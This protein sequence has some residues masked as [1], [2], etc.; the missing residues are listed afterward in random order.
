M[1]LLLT[2]CSDFLEP[3]SQTEFMPREINS[4]NEMLL[5]S[6]YLDPVAQNQYV[7]SY[8]ELFT[9]DMACT[10][11]NGNNISNADKYSRLK[12]YFAWIHA[13]LK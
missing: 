13:C 8:H 9:D 1:I 10:V 6:A 2:S 5:G 4:L 3:K 12:Y 7:F 11:V